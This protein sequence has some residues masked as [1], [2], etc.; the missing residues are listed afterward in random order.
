MTQENVV[1]IW[2]RITVRCQVKVSVTLDFS[3]SA[4]HLGSSDGSQAAHGKSLYA[5]HSPPCWPCISHP[6]LYTD[7]VIP[8]GK[9]CVCIMGGYHLIKW[10][11]FLNLKIK[12]L[13]CDIKYDLSEL[14][15]SYIC[16]SRTYL[17]TEPCHALGSYQPVVCG[18]FPAPCF[19]PDISSHWPVLH[20][21][22]TFQGTVQIAPW[23][24]FFSC[25]LIHKCLGL[26]RLLLQNTLYWV[27]HKQQKCI[28]HS[29]GG[30][31]VQDP[32][33]GSSRWLLKGAFCVSSQAEVLPA[34]FIR[35][36]I[37]FMTS[38]P[39]KGSTS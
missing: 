4:A 20:D 30:W 1:L 17:P 9:E 12:I 39:P 7:L 21:V 23:W 35:V 19:P 38:S 31:E 3:T 36:L 13:T 32:G 11:R 33:A 25:F 2:I 16:V 6:F 34:S 5:A 29:S 28:S 37:A 18:T 27:I 10:N 26:F 15:K 8:K 22:H 14:K 24:N